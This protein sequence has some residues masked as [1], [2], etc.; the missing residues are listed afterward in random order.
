MKG[1]C[2]CG[3]V[4]FEAEPTEMEAHACHCEMCRRWTG[5]ALISVSVAPKAI[6]F[7]GAE[8]IRRFQSSDWAERAW[9]GTCGLHLYYHLT[10]G[11]PEQETYEVTLGLF[12]AP[13]GIALTSEIF[14]DCK[15]A[16]YAFAGERKTMTRAETLEMFGGDGS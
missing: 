1:R 4:S 9:C 5:S 8:H 7:N 16:G 2:M 12:D 15:P 3:A 13:D 11:T 6:Q 14:I 10:G